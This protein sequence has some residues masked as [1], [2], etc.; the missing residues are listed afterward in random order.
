[1]IK[2]KIF[3][4]FILNF[5]FFDFLLSQSIEEK[6]TQLIWASFDIEEKSKLTKAVEQKI[7]GI[8]IIC[9]NH[10]LE[11]TKQTLKK[12]YF[13]SKTP[14]FIS[15]D[16]EGGSVYIHQ[17]HGLLNLPSNM[18]IG[19][20]RAWQDI[21]A[22]S[23]L[24]GLELK[25]AG[26]NT[27]FSP[28]V[29]VNTEEKNPIINI[30]AFSDDKEI[31]LKA[32]ELMIDGF[33]ASQII[34]T[35]KHFPGHGMTVED[36]HKTTPVTKI[37]YD[38]LFETHIYPFKKLIEKNKAEI[39]MLSHVIYK[40]IDEKNPASLSPQIIKILRNDLNFN[41]II[42]TDSLDMKAITDRYSCEKAAVIA[43]KNG[44]DMVLTGRHNWI[45]VKK[46][47]IKAV[48]NGE[49]THNQ[50]NNSYKKIVSLKE[51]YNLKSF[52]ITNIQ[53]DIAYK[54]IA[55]EIS[56]KAISLSKGKLENIK[57]EKLKIIFLIPDRFATDAT[58]FYREM[59]RNEFNVD[60]YIINPSKI[61]QLQSIKNEHNELLLLD[62]SGH[63]SHKKILIH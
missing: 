22:F 11:K 41:G 56:L 32:A 5:I 24:L 20:A 16:Y 17:T 29:D 46:A 28:A 31:V 55:R 1:M 58:I 6:V 25:K 61:N 14:P 10:S 59:I 9:G 47:I 40:N 30:R 18:A 39:I 4:I 37:T 38:E 26:I 50:I 44:V 19:K 7:G 2:E 12:I 21:P 57:N 62:I 36:S 33:N 52:D 42:L 15:I 13:N 54:R 63:I 49:I 3:F 60:F 48:E 34:T 45:K 51:K 8:Q 27:V 23:Y 43:I 35:L 53:F